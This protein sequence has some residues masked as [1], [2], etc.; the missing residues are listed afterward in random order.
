MQKKLNNIDINGDW[1]TCY[2]N[3]WVN[4]EIKEEIKKLS[5]NKWKWTYNTP[6]PMRHSKGS[7]EGEVHSNTGLPKEDRKIL[8]NLTLHLQELEE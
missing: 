1:I 6:E 8:N 7:P 4:N 3:E 2:Y 5:G